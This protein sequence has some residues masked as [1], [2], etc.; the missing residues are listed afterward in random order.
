MRQ[1]H[2]FI[3]QL[4]L[5][6]K[7]ETESHVVNGNKNHNLRPANSPIMALSPGTEPNSPSMVACSQTSWWSQTFQMV[8]LSPKQTHDEL[9]ED[10]DLSNNKEQKIVNKPRNG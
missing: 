1:Y 9:H 6:T 8:S 3:I 2:N 10:D 5:I 7:L 4:R